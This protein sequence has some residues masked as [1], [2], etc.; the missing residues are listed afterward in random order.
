LLSP[1]DKAIGFLISKLFPKDD[2]K[3]FLED[4][5]YEMRKIKTISYKNF[6]ENL[7]LKDH[8]KFN[9]KTRQ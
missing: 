3:I 8:F 4:L 9:G 5:S 1:N 7:T 2:I 6:K